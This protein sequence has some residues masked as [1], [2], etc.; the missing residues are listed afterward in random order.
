MN[1]IKNEKHYIQIPFMFN[2]ERQSGEL[3]VFKDA[4]NKKSG[5]GGAS[6]LIG[7]DTA[8]LGRVESYIVKNEKTLSFQFRSGKDSLRLIGRKFEEFSDKIRSMGY[9]ISG[10]AYKKIDEAFTLVNGINDIKAP[11]S[12]RRRY[13]FDIRV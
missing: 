2:G 10:V 9:T 5:P 6:I 8:R 1:H 4:D 7:L 13:S 12:S 3:Y 11:P